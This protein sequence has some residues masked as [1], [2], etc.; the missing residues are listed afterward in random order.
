MLFNINGDWF[1]EVSLQLFHH[2]PLKMA[3]PFMHCIVG[4]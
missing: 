4:E 3:P 1:S 2:K